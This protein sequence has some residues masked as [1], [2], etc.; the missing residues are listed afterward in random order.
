MLMAAGTL[1]SVSV[2]GLFSFDMYLNTH[3]QY[4][5]NF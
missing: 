5:V 2:G 4:E 3:F 1:R